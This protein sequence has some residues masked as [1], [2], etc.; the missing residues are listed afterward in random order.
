MA[1][2]LMVMLL[3]GGA[4][5]FIAEQNKKRKITSPVSDDHL[6][7]IKN[8]LKKS[9]FFKEEDAHKLID[10]VNKKIS[11]KQEEIIQQNP[12]PV[13]IPR[14]WC[15]NDKRTTCSLYDKDKH[16]PTDCIGDINKN[17]CMDRIKK[18]VA[19][20]NDKISQIE[21]YCARINDVCV[22]YKNKKYARKMDHELCGKLIHNCN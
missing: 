17:Q 4:A 5:A 7:N 9:K 18:Y 20:E 12:V 8:F 2:I 10:I 1:E 14:A 15:P 13:S 6:K 11:G 3:L 19:V 21:D 22:T 16:F